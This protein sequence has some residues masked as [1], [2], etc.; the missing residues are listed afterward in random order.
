LEG[1]LFEEFE[2][3]MTFLDFRFG[4]GRAFHSQLK[5]MTPFS[6]H[7]LKTP[8]FHHFSSF[9]TTLTS[10]LTSLFF[11]TRKHHTKHFAV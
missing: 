5:R 4:E 11:Q 6:R 1:A 7:T 10:E 8:Q 9:Y 3:L 2:E